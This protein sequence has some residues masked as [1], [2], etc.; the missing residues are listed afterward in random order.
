MWFLRRNESLLSRDFIEQVLFLKALVYLADWSPEIETA[1]LIETTSIPRIPVSSFHTNKQTGFHLPIISWGRLGFLVVHVHSH[2][3]EGGGGAS[4][5]G[6]FQWAAVSWRRWYFFFCRKMAGEIWGNDVWWY[7]GDLHPRKVKVYHGI[8]HPRVFV[9]LVSHDSPHK[10]VSKQT[11]ARSLA[12]PALTS[13][14]L[15]RCEGCGHV[16]TFDT[17]A[18]HLRSEL[19]FQKLMQK[20]LVQSG[21]APEE[22]RRERRVR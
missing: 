21:D 7:E 9:M 22:F 11:S 13:P 15:R 18:E 12:F 19:H 8:I 2:P 10:Y 20:A 17:L 3:Q 1:N 4:S 6:T 16:V 14:V 5:V